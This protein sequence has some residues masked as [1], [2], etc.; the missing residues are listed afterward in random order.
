[1]VGLV[2]SVEEVADWIARSQLVP[3]SVVQSFIE[4]GAS[5]NQQP[6][7]IS[8]PLISPA[9]ITGYDFPELLENDGIL[10]ETELGVTRQTIKKRLMRGMK[11]KLLGM[12]SPPPASPPP[13]VRLSEQTLCYTNLQIEW[14]PVPTDLSHLDVY[15]IHLYRLQRQEQSS[16]LGGP[17]LGLKW[18]TVYEGTERTCFD[19]IFTPPVRTIDENASGVGTGVTTVSY[20]LASWN[21]IGR[22]EYSYLKYEITR[23]T[24]SSWGDQ[25]DCV[26]QPYPGPQSH[27]TANELELLFLK[28]LEL[29]NSSPA[30]ETRRNASPSLN[31]Q[32]PT[33]QDTSSESKTWSISSFFTFILDLLW[34]L[35]VIYS[36]AR[37]WLWTSL[38]ILS[39][40]ITLLYLYLRF[41]PPG[42][43]SSG[44]PAP[45][46][47]H[48]PIMKPFLTALCSV[49]IRWSKYFSQKFP[50]SKPTFHSFILLLES[51]PLHDS[52]TTSPRVVT[53]TTTTLRQHRILKRMNSARSVGED[54]ADSQNSGTEEGKGCSSGDK[55]SICSR[56]FKLQVS[57]PKIKWRVKHH[58]YVCFNL[59]CSKCGIVTHANLQCPVRGSCC[60]Q[61]CAD[62][63][64]QNRDGGG[65]C[66]HQQV[67][68]P[69]ASCD[70]CDDSSSI[71]T[72]DSLELSE[73]SDSAIAA[74]TLSN[75]KKNKS[76]ASLK[77]FGIGIG[78]KSEKEKAHP[79]KFTFDDA[80]N[81]APGIPPRP[82]STTKK[83]HWPSIPSLGRRVTSSPPSIPSDRA[84]SSCVPSPPDLT[85]SSWPGAEQ[86]SGD[87]YYEDLSERLSYS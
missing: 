57:F 16:P 15:P 86:D 5:M 39:V 49:L 64:N 40:P 50:S 56:P 3:D 19:K 34:L 46:W 52:Q 29:A 72:T 85:T 17:S 41:N 82:A 38:S 80:A 23:P 27:L 47:L 21:V 48:S 58:C 68:G 30:S 81:T 14:N 70:H 63:L 28:N 20:R 59:F 9:A 2:L 10:L 87:I 73:K 24:V 51:I 60:C 18:V 74:A 11:M 22:S 83:L 42:V 67:D 26:D 36:T 45:H 43:D 75:K 53:V 44:A 78:K 79:S 32:P 65:S 61:R 84:K 69:P 71:A 12:G 4:N 37:S 33:E 62:A 13:T 54:S 8:S 66:S 55:C 35:W 25:D 31:Q 77:D 1:M 7:L 6:L 76:F